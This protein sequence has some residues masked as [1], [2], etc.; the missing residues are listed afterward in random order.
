[1]HALREVLLFCTVLAYYSFWLVF[2]CG[3]ILRFSTDFH[4][5]PLRIPGQLAIC[6][7]HFRR[8]ESLRCSSRK[9]VRLFDI[10]NGLP[11][12]HPKWSLLLLLLVYLSFV[13]AFRYYTTEYLRVSLLLCTS[14][15]PCS[16]LQFERF[17]NVARRGSPRLSL[18][19]S[20]RF[21]CWSFARCL[22]SRGGG[23]STR[24]SP[25]RE[26]RDSISF[27]RRTK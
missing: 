7:E 20:C 21:Y 1:M 17:S 24:C 8:M 14:F 2:H 6:P 4:P 22:H 16:F 10:F 3:P 9:F 26:E 13:V 19:R 5:I 27:S 12:I 18:Q 25:G 11:S 15:L 23:S